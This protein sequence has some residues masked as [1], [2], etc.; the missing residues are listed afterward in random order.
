MAKS[1]NGAK[2]QAASKW[3]EEVPIVPNLP[4]VEDDLQQQHEYVQEQKQRDNAFS[5]VAPEAFVQSIRDLGYKSTLT[6]LDE[7]VDSSLRC[8]DA[9][10]DDL[11]TVVER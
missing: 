11:C 3:A 10:D 4:D 8:F 7:L 9:A 2:P 5:L 1:K 6:A